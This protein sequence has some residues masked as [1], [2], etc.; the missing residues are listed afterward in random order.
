MTTQPPVPEPVE[1]PKTQNPKSKIQMKPKELRIGNLFN[2]HEPVKVE[3]W[4]LHPDSKIVFEPIPLTSEWLIRFGADGANIDD[5]YIDVHNEI[6]YS[7]NIYKTS[8]SDW[9]VTL[10]T[11]SS[12]ISLCEIKYVHQLQN[13]YF[14]ITGEELT[15]NQ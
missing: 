4:M 15:S 8:E 12:V 14:A 13:L 3:W 5:L 10:W 9:A 7:L 6:K 11:S 1:G 2:P